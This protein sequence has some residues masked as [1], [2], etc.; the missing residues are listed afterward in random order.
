KGRILSGD[1]SALEVVVLA[2]LSGDTHLKEVLAKGTDMHCLRLSKSLNE[3]YDE[4]YQKCH[5]PQ[6]PEYKLYDQLRDDIKIPSFA[7]QYGATAYGIMYTA[8]ITL[9]AAEKFIADEK[10]LFP[11]VE[12]W[13]ENEVFPEVNRNTQSHREQGADG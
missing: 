4:V 5:D 8:G 12:S 13:Y 9:E 6:H 10:A 11:E 2:A 3:P 1:F 7:Y